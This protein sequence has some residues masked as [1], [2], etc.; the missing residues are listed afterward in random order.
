MILLK[1]DWMVDLAMSIFEFLTKFLIFWHS[2]HPWVCIRSVGWK[3]NLKQIKA[4]PPSVPYILGDQLTLSMYLNRG[5]RLCPHVIQGWRKQGAGGAHAPPD[6]GRLVNLISTSTTFLL[7]TPDF[8]TFPHPCHHYLPP[9]FLDLPTFLLY[10][11]S[12]A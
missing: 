7:A 11:F 1:F 12:E 2:W 6:F 5:G 9:R 4:I 10:N 8:Q 3:W